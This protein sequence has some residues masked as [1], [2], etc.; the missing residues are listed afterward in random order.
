[1]LVSRVVYDMGLPG[2]YFRSRYGHNL[3]NWALFEPCRLRNMKS[4]RVERQHPALARGDGDFGI[5]L[6]EKVELAFRPASQRLFLSS[7]L[8]PAAHVPLTRAITNSARSSTLTRGN[9]V[10]S[11]PQLR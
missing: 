5:A 9:S 4:E 10:N 11:Y 8:Q 3:E 7:R 6:R 1:M 2:I